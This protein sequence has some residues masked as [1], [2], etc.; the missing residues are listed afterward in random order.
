MEDSQ[1]PLL[2]PTFAAPTVRSEDGRLE[3]TDTTL[4]VDGRVFSLL[5]LE[6]V[7]VKPVRWLLWYLLGGLTLAIFT[8]AFLQNWL[9]TMPAAMGM[10]V[11]ALLL[12]IGHRGAKRLRILRLGQEDLYYSLSGELA[13][14]QALVSQVNRRIQQRHDEQAVLLFQAVSA[15][16]QHNEEATEPEQ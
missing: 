5:E 12:L 15:M 3:L 8:M 7:E 2:P 9:R 6:A 16:Q 13:P 14:W 4:K 10:T 11:G 1:L